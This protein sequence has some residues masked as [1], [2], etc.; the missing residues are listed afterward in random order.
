MS[1]YFGA[2]GQE[3]N[4]GSL[5]ADNIQPRQ[6]LINFQNSIKKLIFPAI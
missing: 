3:F 2:R 5:S 1:V 6:V 4:F